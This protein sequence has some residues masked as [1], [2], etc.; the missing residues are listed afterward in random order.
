MNFPLIANNTVRDSFLNSYKSGRIPHAIIIEGES[1][2]GKTEFA[3]FIAKTVFC[4]SENK[5]CGVC[6]SCNL[7]EVG[8]HLDLHTVT[9]EETKKNIKVDQIR[10]L[11]FRAYQKPGVSDTNFFIIDR[12]ETLNAAAQNAILK[13]LEEPPTSS[14]F[15]FLTTSITN[16]LPTVI[17]RCIVYSLSV[18]TVNETAELLQSKNLCDKETAYRVSK[19]AGGNVKTALSLLEKGKSDG[20]TAI[21][22]EYLNAILKRDLYSLLLIPNAI[23]GNRALTEEFITELKNIMLGKLKAN[24]HDKGQTKTYLKLIEFTD[25]LFDPLKTNIQLSLLFSHMAYSYFEIS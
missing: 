7:A 11:I 21:A 22:E 25:S 5:P 6:K 8:T 10:D 13:V 23:S 16:L 3:K 9:P 1:G 4:E 18:P 20:I 24:I 12:A 19:E 17:S 15:I 2:S 14:I